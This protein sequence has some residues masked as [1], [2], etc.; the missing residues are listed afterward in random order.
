MNKVQ[1]QRHEYY[2]KHKE[3]CIRRAKTRYKEKKNDPVFYQ[4]LLERNKKYKKDGPMRRSQKKK[5]LP[6]FNKIVLE[7]KSYTKE[8]ECEKKKQR[9]EYY[10][11][12]KDII[13]QKARDRYKEKK[14]DPEYY[15]TMLE[16]NQISYHRKVNNID[17]EP[18]T[19]EQEDEFFKKIARDV[20]AVNELDKDKRPAFIDYN[21]THALFYD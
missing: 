4:A 16:K 7:K 15:R 13:N 18:W 17:A 1:Q 3:S 2:L 5:S 6:V 11:K 19:Q 20:R 14:L 21:T 12:R 10:L 8:M 9:H